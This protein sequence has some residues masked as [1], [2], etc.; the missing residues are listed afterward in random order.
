[1]RTFSFEAI[2][3]SWKIDID[4][5]TESQFE[6]LKDVIKER[7]AV[8][9]KN[10]SRFREDSLVMEMAQRP[11]EYQ[12]PEDG[13]EMMDLYQKLYEITKGKFTPLI[14]DVLV[15][16]GYDADY[17]L[18]PKEVHSPFK[19]SE[20]L[21][22]HFP[23]LILKKPTILDFGGLGKGYLIDIISNLIKSDGI[24]NFTV[25][26]GGDM[27]HE[28]KDILAVGLEHP[29]N[30]NQVIG[31]IKV[32]NGSLCASSGSRRKWD[33]YH[34]II[35][36]DTL[37]APKEILA[38]WVTAETTLL[39]DAIATCLFLVPSSILKDEF[40]FEYVTLFSD[41]SIE[42]SQ[43]FNAEIFTAE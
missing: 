12:L 18:I 28:G 25:D 7:I 24:K 31:Q 36:P 19:W 11:G 30:Q 29:E 3:T 9:D 10:Y 8:F 14:G 41:Y 42:K 13:R 39:A 43:N 26:A 40:S 1:M 20:I 33:V 27:Y 22:Y 17:S 5:I 6:S 16:V 15:E 38:T 34:H 35:D 21:D 37:S 4:D 2:G 32:T 23:T